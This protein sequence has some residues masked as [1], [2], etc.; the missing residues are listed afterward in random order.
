MEKRPRPNRGKKANIP[1]IIAASLFTMAM[2]SA[3][4]SRANVNFI[5]AGST[6]VQPYAEILTED[7]AHIHPDKIIDVQGGGSSAGI[8]AVIS[9]TADIGMSSRALKD[10][11]SWLWSAEIAKDGLSVIVHPDNPVSD[12]S[13]EDVRAIYSGDIRDWGELGGARSEIH[14]ITREEGSGTRGA[15]EDL[16]MDRL[17]IAPKAIVQDSNGAVKQLVKDDVKSIGFISMGLVDHTVKALRLGGAEPT[18]ENVAS[19]RYSL[20]RPFLF[21]VKGE[22]E[23]MAKQF[24]DY[25][26]SGEGQRQLSAEGLIIMEESSRQ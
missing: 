13:P 21:V 1:I 6:S 15:F 8:E 7:Y 24:I 10:G 19:G 18:R 14:L 5:V 3:C 2:Q 16:V 20:Y 11:E 23:G 26:L 17:E 9:G 12:L 25:V 4:G 22:P